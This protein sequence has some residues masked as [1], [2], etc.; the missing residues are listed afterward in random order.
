M[1]EQP[2]AEEPSAGDPSPPAGHPLAALIGGPRG[3]IESILPPVAFVA[4][5]VGTDSIGWASLVVLVVALALAIWRMVRGERPIRVLGA[6][7]VVMLGALVASLSGSAVA[8]FWPLVIA[9]ILSALAFAFSIAIRWPLLGVIVGPVVGTGMRWRKDPD[10]LRAY[11]RASWVWVGLNVIRAAVQIPLIQGDDLWALAA[12]RLVFYL[13]VIATV[14][15]SWIV[16]RNS[17]PE[18]HPGIRH[19][20]ALPASA[21]S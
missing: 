11:S 19:P 18:G 5:Y 2:A 16:I 14:L 17:L 15:L 8:Y 20:R 1:T 4:T 9:N 13:L 10:L 12:V 7:F 21:E 3:A 6:L